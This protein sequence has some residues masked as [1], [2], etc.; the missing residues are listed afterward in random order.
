MSLVN[1]MCSMDSSTPRSPGSI[2][3]NC[4]ISS[5]ALARVTGPPRPVARSRMLT[6]W[7]APPVKMRARRM[8]MPPG[9]W[10]QRSTASKMRSSSPG[11][12]Q[13]MVTISTCQPPSASGMASISSPPSSASRF[14]LLRWRCCSSSSVRS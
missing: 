14:S 8:A 10:T 6:T 13:S 5:S 11:S 7:P 3:R 9:M 4:S 1:G 12:S 2:C